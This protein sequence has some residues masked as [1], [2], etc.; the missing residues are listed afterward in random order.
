MPRKVTCSLTFQIVITCLDIGSAN[1]FV[2]G[3]AQLP[4]AHR[5]VGRLGAALDA[6]VAHK[7]QPQRVVVESTAADVPAADDAARRDR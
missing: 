7:D 1:G 2:V 3:R 5:E 4:P 6:D